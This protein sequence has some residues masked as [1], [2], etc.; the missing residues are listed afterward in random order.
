MYIGRSYSIAPE[1]QFVTLKFH[2][3]IKDDYLIVN[4]LNPDDMKKNNKMWAHRTTC[5]T[6]AE[7]LRID[8]RSE[9]ILR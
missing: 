5:T 4:V 1:K 3:P 7:W 2:T 8:G 9:R 6:N